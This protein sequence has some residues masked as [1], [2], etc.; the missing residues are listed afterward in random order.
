M[1]EEQRKLPGGSKQWLQENVYNNNKVIGKLDIKNT[2]P[3]SNN[4][5]DNAPMYHTLQNHLLLL[6]YLLKHRNWEGK[7]KDKHKTVEIWRDKKG[8]LV[9]SRSQERIAKDLKIPMSTLKRW[10]RELELD[11]LIRRIKEFRENVYVLGEIVDGK[12]EYYYA[13]KYPRINM[14]DYLL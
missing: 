11:G 10:L 6:I 13:K 12:E 8:L 7:G 14:S 2:T 1:L 3:I 4:L 9:C 5:F